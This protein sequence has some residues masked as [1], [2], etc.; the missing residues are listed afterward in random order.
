MTGMIGRLSTVALVVGAA[1]VWPAHDVRAQLPVESSASFA[2][3]HSHMRA[4]TVIAHVV[5]YE[6]GSRIVLRMQALEVVDAALVAES[7]AVIRVGSARFSG[8]IVLEA[9]SLSGKLFGQVAVTL[10]TNM[11]LPPLPAP[12]VTLTDVVADDVRISASAAAV[13][14]FAIGR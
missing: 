2:T 13:R 11:P 12:Y 6:Q 4:R 9:K 14:H 3:A 7:G 8:V 10:S 1:V 5:R